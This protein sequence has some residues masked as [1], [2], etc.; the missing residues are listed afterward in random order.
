MAQ[1][2]KCGRCGQEF[3]TE[4]E[5]C[6]HICPETGFTPKDADHHGAEFKAVQDA[7][8]QRGEERKGEETHPAEAAAK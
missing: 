3:K 1:I 2:H 4:K 6:D 5:Y 8:L 7:A